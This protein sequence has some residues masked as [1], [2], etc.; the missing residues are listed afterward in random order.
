MD[1]KGIVIWIVGLVVLGLL[2]AY[3]FNQSRQNRS[4]LDL[5]ASRNV[6]MMREALGKSKTDLQNEIRSFIHYKIALHPEFQVQAGKEVVAV[7]PKYFRPTEVD[8]LIGDPTKAMTKL[9]WQPKYD[10][11]MLVKDMVE[12]DVELFKKEKLLKDSGFIVNDAHE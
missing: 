1:R 8:L 2:A 4:Q 12:S 5:Q 3:L 6:L 10:L 11:P 7:D 9:D